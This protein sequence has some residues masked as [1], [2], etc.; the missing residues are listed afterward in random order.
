MFARAHLGRTKG[1]P[2]PRFRR[3]SAMSPRVKTL[4]LVLPLFAVAG[5]PRTALSVW[6]T[7][8]TPVCMLDGSQES[9]AIT[10]DGAGG[11]IITWSDDR[12]SSQSDI[13]AQR[14]DGSGAPLWIGG[15]V[16]VCTVS[17]GQTSPH[18]LSDFANGAFVVWED[19]RTGG[20]GD[21]L[22]AQR[23]SSVGSPVWTLNGIPLVTGD[24]AFRNVNTIGDGS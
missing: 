2:I 11:A 21:G 13:F 12:F 4:V 24:L 20:A 18:I 16:P 19:S 7:N 9:S 14:L 15:G 17:F 23:M 3:W 5:L 8:G 10:T 6:A 1:R 22:Y